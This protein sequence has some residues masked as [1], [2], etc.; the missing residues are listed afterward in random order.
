[1]LYYS[2]LPSYLLS[3]PT[4]C[5]IGLYNLIKH[6]R[7]KHNLWSNCS[8]EHAVTDDSSFNSEFRRQW[9]HVVS[10]NCVPGQTS[11]VIQPTNSCFSS[12]SS[13][14]PGKSSTSCCPWV[15][16]SLWVT[17]SQISSQVMRGAEVS[18]DNHLLECGIRWRSS[19]LTDQLKTKHI[20]RVCVGTSGV[21]TLFRISLNLTSEQASW[22]TWSQ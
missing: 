18:S 9:S 16:E 4:I 11:G 14:R 7:E 1:M 22:G 21:K 10:L 2:I 13:T 20:V 17:F 5:L 19:V 8:T 12:N 6:N 15:R 3:F